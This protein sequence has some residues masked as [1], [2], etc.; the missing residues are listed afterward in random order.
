MTLDLV[1]TVASQ[2]LNFVRHP[3]G[4]WAEIETELGRVLY[5]LDLGPFSFS[6]MMFTFISP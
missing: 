4:R 2:K 1:S 5:E 6:R 3:H